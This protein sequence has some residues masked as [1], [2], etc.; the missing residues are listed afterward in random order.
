[1]QWSIGYCTPQRVSGLESKLVSRSRHFHRMS[2]IVT[3]VQAALHPFHINDSSLSA[4]PQ[5]ARLLSRHDP[6]LL[7][8]P[9][10][11]SGVQNNRRALR[12]VRRRQVQEIV[13]VGVVYPTCPKSSASCISQHT[14]TFSYCEKRARMREDIPD[15]L[16]ITRIYPELPCLF[17]APGNDGRVAR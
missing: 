2:T 6:P 7:I 11:L 10:V 14:L 3:V 5:P 15:E 4:V 8:N 17:R 1:M 13:R 16:R 9:R 12:G